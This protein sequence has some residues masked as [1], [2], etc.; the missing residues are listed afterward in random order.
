MTLGH[1]PRPKKPKPKL[2]TIRDVMVARDQLPR[3]PQPRTIPYFYTKAGED[4]PLGE[5]LHVASIPDPMEV[6][7]PLPFHTAGSVH[8]SPGRVPEELQWQAPFLDTLTQIIGHE[9]GFIAAKPDM[10]PH[11]WGEFMGLDRS[12]T[13]GGKILPPDYF[14]KRYSSNDPSGLGSVTLDVDPGEVR[15][16]A[17]HEW[18]H[19]LTNQEDP[20]LQAFINAAPTPK[21]LRND[22]TIPKVD[23]NQWPPD[24][25]AT[26]AFADMF[27]GALRKQLPGMEPRGGAARTEYP[28]TPQFGGRS[29][30]RMVDSLVNVLLPRLQP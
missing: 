6:V 8:L 30:Q 13:L 10:D 27:A 7:H 29:R 16:S 17:A 15:T 22:P 11:S 20:I 14:K 25:I 19:L 3:A 18:G 21:T 9:P 26:E 5:R 1:G 2:P 23:F 28:F 4:T 24:L 12:I